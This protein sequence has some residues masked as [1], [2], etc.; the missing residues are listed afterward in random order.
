L[1]DPFGPG[2]CPSDRTGFASMTQ[3]DF[4]AFVKAS[5]PPLCR[6][7]MHNTAPEAVVAEA[8]ALAA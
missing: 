5:I 6:R 3:D 7:F 2:F 1:G 4:E 8:M